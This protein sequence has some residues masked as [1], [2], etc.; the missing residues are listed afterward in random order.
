MNQKISTG[1][2]LAVI[3]LIAGAFGLI[4]WITNK[5]ETVQVQLVKNTKKQDVVLI[6]RD[7][8]IYEI[9]L[10]TKNLKPYNNPVGNLAE[11]TGLP[12]ETKT[13]QISV[14]N[15]LELLSQ[16]KSRAI[17]VSRTFDETK[18]PME[19]DGSLPILKKAEFIC[20]TVIKECSPTDFLD[21]AYKATGL[22]VQGYDGGYA[23]IHWFK[24]DFAKNILYGHLTGDGVGNA[25]PVYIFNS[26]TK[27]LQQTIGY[28]SWNDKEK[29]AE[30]PNGTFSSSLSKFIMIDEGRSVDNSDNRWE[31]LL[32]DSNNLSTSLKKFDISIMN[33]KNDSNGRI[34]SVAWSVDEKNLVLET[35]KQIYTLN[36]DSGKITLIYTDTTQDDSGLWLDFNAVSLSSSGQYVVFVDY[37]KRSTPYDENK[38]NPVLKAIDLKDNNKEIELLREKNISL[39]YNF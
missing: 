28:D 30:V 29:R 34:S 27:I 35:N 9:D 19:F 37:D 5:N 13:S 8:G 12:R 32:Y 26:N 22:S 39:D 17:V 18:E 25:S 36:L 21:S 20:N 11:F 7:K 24:W 23:G 38:M 2:T 15:Y 33:D 16:D 10:N 1:F 4:F 31:L 3:I 14:V 6:N